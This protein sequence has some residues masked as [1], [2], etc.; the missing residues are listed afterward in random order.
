MDAETVVVVNPNS[1]GGATGRKW[2]DLARPLAAA[3]GNVEVLF[4]D[5]PN[6]ATALTRKALRAGAKLVISVGGDGTHNEVANGFFD[7]TEAVAP[8]AAM[9]VIPAG[10][11]G[12]FRR[13]FGWSVD[14][15]D[16]VGR[17]ASGKK[18]PIDVGRLRYTTPSGGNA[19]RHF[20]NITSFGIGGKVDDQV[21]RAP[22]L[23]GG[24]AAFAI[25][26]L[27]ALAAYHDQR[28]KVSLD[29]GA[30]R[31]LSITNVAVCNGQFFGG[32]MWA[33]PTAKL[34]DGLFDVTIWSGLGL[35]DFVFKSK[36]LYDGTHVKLPQ[37]ITAQ[38]RKVEATSDEVVLL[39]VD[40]EQPGRLPASMEILPGALIVQG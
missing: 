39:D 20:V 19:L 26:S 1:A 14:P 10:T 40:G 25:A 36:Q 13:S 27:R 15:R 23:F 21:V 9:G 4:T 31:E 5:A 33:A 22:R 18:R 2:P 38:A 6:A 8:Q 37:T 34:D 12:D 11:G 24:K 32:G 17:L 29:G 7:G 35:S 30:P 16:A 3:L 28:V